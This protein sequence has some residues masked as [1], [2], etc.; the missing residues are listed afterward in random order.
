MRQTIDQSASGKLRDLNPEESWAILEDL[1]LY[2]NEIQNDTK[3]F[4][5]PVKDI[6]LPQDY[7]MENPEQAFIEYAS[8]CTDEAGGKCSINTITIH[9][10][11]QS[12]SRD[13]R[14]KENEEEEG[15]SSESHSDSLTPPNPSISFLAKKVLKFNSLFE[16]LG[17]I[18]PSPNTELVYTKEEDGNVMFVEIIPKDDDS[19]ARRN[20]KQKGNK[21]SILTYSRLG[22]NSHITNPRLSQVVL[23]R[24]FI[25]ISNMTQDPPEGVV[26]FIKRTDEVAYKMP[27]KIEQ[28]DS[29]MS[30]LV[31]VKIEI[32]T[33][34]DGAQSSRVPVPLP[35][36]PY[37]AIRQA[38]L[39]R[40]DTK[41]EPFEG[42][43][44]A[45][46]LPHTL[47]SPTALPDSTPPTC[48]VEESKGSDTFGVRSMSS[49]STAPLSPDHPITYTTPTLVPILR[50]S[51]RM[52]VRV[53]PT[54]LPGLSTSMTEV[55][56]MSDLAFLE[57]D[58]D[59]EDDEEED[60]E[61]E[62]SLDFDSVSEGAENKGPSVEDNLAAGDEATPVQ[63]PPSPGWSS[64]SLL[65][66]SAPSIVPSPIISLSVLLPIASPA[67]AKTEG[68]LTEV[69]ARVETNLEHKQERVA[70]TFGAIWRPILAQESWV[71]Q[72]DAQRAAL[73]HAISDTH[74]ENQDLRLQLVEERRTRLELGEI[75]D[76]MR[77][78][79][80]VEALEELL[81]NQTFHHNFAPE[82]VLLKVSGSDVVSHPR[83][84]FKIKES[85]DA[86]PVDAD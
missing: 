29:L 57:D 64:G 69:G 40:T 84:S 34:A 10:K 59:A 81:S 83:T 1:T 7:C 60:G 6:T 30:T 50:R 63:T 74:R 76:S 49:D 47:V 58:M 38:Y 32:F 21:W 54:M 23:G 53:P 26:R 80:I 39:V 61:M 37:E 55:A 27:H 73:W 14:T 52:A 42:E 17:L 28:Y 25:D 43:T 11:Q 62:E 20:L 46:K 68:F 51:A 85:E 71:G 72:T 56:A 9:L 70:V 65:I 3:D 19:P 31:F 18:P 16:S 35:E 41:S 79:G 13:D 75:I 66:F 24:P 22:V 15:D 45:P 2:D 5:K 78:W 33:Q 86:S 48:H 82:H 8:S 77:R 67:T 36:D 12:N 44:K 4:P